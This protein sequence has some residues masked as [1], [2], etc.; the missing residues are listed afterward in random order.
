MSWFT[1][2]ISTSSAM[3]E[4]SQR[5]GK[6]RFSTSLHSH[7]HVPSSRNPQ[8]RREKNPL[9]NPFYYDEPQLGLTL[10]VKVCWPP[11][12]KEDGLIIRW[13]IMWFGRGIAF[14]SSSLFKTKVL[15]IIHAHILSSPQLLTIKPQELPLLLWRRFNDVKNNPQPNQPDRICQSLWPF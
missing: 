13:W 6:H 1:F 7:V 5:K 4:D 2:I 8:K 3:V 14:T 15:P 9:I 10:M 11:F 12:K